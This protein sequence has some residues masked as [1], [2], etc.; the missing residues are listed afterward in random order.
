MLEKHQRHLKTGQLKAY[1]VSHREDL[2]APAEVAAFEADE[3]SKANKTREGWDKF[4]RWLDGREVE[5]P[6][7]DVKPILMVL[8]W[9]AIACRMP[10]IGFV[11]DLLDWMQQ[12]EQNIL[13]GDREAQRWKNLKEALDREREVTRRSRALEAARAESA[14]ELPKSKPKP[15]AAPVPG[16]S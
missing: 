1:L 2:P 5:P 9:L 11:A 7:C 15:P 6:F 13:I 4:N 3:P 14:F 16:D 8:R 10:W 12:R